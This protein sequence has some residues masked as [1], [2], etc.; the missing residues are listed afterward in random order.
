VTVEEAQKW[1]LEMERIVQQQLPY[2]VL[3]R[4]PVIEAFSDRVQFPVAA[5]RGGHSAFPNAWPASVRLSD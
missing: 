1:T 5:I 4:L 3:F 2:L